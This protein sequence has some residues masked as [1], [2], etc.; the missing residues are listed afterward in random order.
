MLLLGRVALNKLSWKSGKGKNG[1]WQPES[2]GA[3]GEKD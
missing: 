3:F 1:A 2:E